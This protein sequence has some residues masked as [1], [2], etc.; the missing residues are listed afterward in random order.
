MSHYVFRKSVALVLIY[1]YEFYH[2]FE[3]EQKIETSGSTS[4]NSTRQPSRPQNKRRKVT[5]TQGLTTEPKPTC[6]VNV[7]HYII[8]IDH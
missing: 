5:A 4:S 6:R 3:I 7:Y 8:H 1:P 2:T